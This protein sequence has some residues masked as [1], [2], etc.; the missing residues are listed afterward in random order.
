VHFCDGHPPRLFLELLHLLGH[1][2]HILLLIIAQNQVF[3]K[4]IQS[5]LPSKKKPPPMSPS[6]Q[7]LAKPAAT[8]K[9]LASSSAA[10]YQEVGERSLPQLRR[11]EQEIYGWI[12]TRSKIDLTG[13]CAA[14]ALNPK[15]EG[16]KPTIH[17]IKKTYI[18]LLIIELL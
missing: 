11:P 17:T 4:I 6:P 10:R 14:E 2:R 8:T 15:R 16:K 5:R 9:T 12:K 13:L 3:Q 18:N 1:N 7:T